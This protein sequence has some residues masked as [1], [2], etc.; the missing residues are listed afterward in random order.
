M[1]SGLVGLRPVKRLTVGG[2]LYSVVALAVLAVVTVSANGVT[3]KN[4]DFTATSTNDPPGTID[5][6][7]TK[8][9]ATCTSA[10]VNSELVLVTIT[11]GY[12]SYTCTFT[13]TAKNTGTLDIKLNPL[14]FDVPPVLTVTDLSNDEGIVLGGGSKVVERFSV[15]VEQPAHQG[16]TYT[17]EI[18]KPFRLFQT[19]TIGFW[20]N[21][22]RNKKFTRTQIE[23]WLIQIDNSSQWFGPRTV[24]GMVSTIDAAN[25]GQATPRTRFIAQC[26]AT[27]L[28]ERSTILEGT[29]THNVTSVD[30]TNYLGLAN[31]S[32]ATLNQIIAAIESKYGT[33]VNNGRYEIMKNV[34]DRLNN[35]AI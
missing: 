19:G 16:S 22:D 8:N 20:R 13:V 4:V 10:L 17:F 28:N 3:L 18:R 7:Y 35:L 12:P 9:V 26:L 25:G 14:E 29:D 24:T 2:A 6:G 27:R 1:R 30:P 31:P 34:C 11:N 15:H 21:W 33:S 5:P 23:G 32:A